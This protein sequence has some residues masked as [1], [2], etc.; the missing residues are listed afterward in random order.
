MMDVVHVIIYGT[1][2]T[3]ILMG[4]SHNGS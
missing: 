3:T 1:H 2:Q 4:I